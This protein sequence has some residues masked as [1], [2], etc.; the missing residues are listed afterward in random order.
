MAETAASYSGAV[1]PPDAAVTVTLKQCLHLFFYGCRF[2]RHP[3]P[4]DFDVWDICGYPFGFTT[5]YGIFQ[6]EILCSA[7]VFHFRYYS[8]Y[9]IRHQ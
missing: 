9:F 4:N 7:D 6:R 3:I 1:S 2:R 8:L 5:V